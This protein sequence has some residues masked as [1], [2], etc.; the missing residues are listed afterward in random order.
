M[1]EFILKECAA[2][3]PYFRIRDPLKVVFPVRF[4]RQ[5]LVQVYQ[6]LSGFHQHC[7]RGAHDLLKARGFRQCP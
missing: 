2:I 5:Q 7:Q 3:R 4:I 1:I 6:G